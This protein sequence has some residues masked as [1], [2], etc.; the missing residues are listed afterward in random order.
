M[1]RIGWNMNANNIRK[2]TKK[3]SDNR[4]SL[5]LNNKQ[6]QLKDKMVIMCWAAV[7]G[8]VLPQ[9]WQLSRLL[10][11][12]QLS[13]RH[14]MLLIL[15]FCRA[16]KYR[17]VCNVHA[18]CRLGAESTS[19]SLEHVLGATGGAEGGGWEARLANQRR[20]ESGRLTSRRSTKMADSPTGLSSSFLC[21]Y[22]AKAKLSV[23][24]ARRNKS[25]SFSEL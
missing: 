18:L 5:S 20:G 3:I 2:S 23:T 25:S 21:L 11:P 9:H 4:L 17:S 7:Y 1:F 6:Q 15:Q 16:I 10:Q 19:R 12:C 24:A 22:C 14:A 8:Y 13:L